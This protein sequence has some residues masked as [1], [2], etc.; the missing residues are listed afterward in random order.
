M[1]AGAEG[2]AVG[3]DGMGE[4]ASWEAHLEVPF[5]TLDGV[6]E[7]EPFFVGT[8][9][10]EVDGFGFVA[11]EGGVEVDSEYAAFAECGVL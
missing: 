11:L 5:G 10:G 7:E 8:V 1:E 4:P 9:D 2:E 6:G 3:V